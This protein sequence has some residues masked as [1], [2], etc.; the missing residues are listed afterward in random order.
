[1][2]HLF[3]F[4][5]PGEARGC[6]TNNSVVDLKKIVLKNF[7][8]KQIFESG[9]SKMVRC[10]YILKIVFR[11]DTAIHFWQ[12]YVCPLQPVWSICL[13]ISSLIPSNDVLLALSEQSKGP[14]LST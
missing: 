2:I 8:L 12:I 14:H 11:D 4:S 6:S 10:L 3:T 13:P 1:M 9:G 7:F 5:R